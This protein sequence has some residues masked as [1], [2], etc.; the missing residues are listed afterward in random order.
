MQR[1]IAIIVIAVWL[2]LPL[3]VRADS[4]VSLMVF[5]SITL[6]QAVGLS[7]LFGFTGQISLGQA[8]F[9]GIGAYVS[10]IAAIRF[11]VP[12]LLGLVLAAIAP[13]ILAYVIGRPILRLKGY[14][15]A[16]VTAGLGLILHTVFVEWES[17]TGGY[18][19]VAGIPPL[20]IGT[21]A[22]DTPRTMF[23]FAAFCALLILIFAHRMVG[24][25]YGRAM[26]TTRE[27]EAA[28][29]SVGID[30]PRLKTEV[31][32]LS[33]G[34]SGFAGGLY[35][36]YVG[37]ISPETFTMDT[38]INLLLALVVGG[39]GSLWGGAVGAILLTFLPEWLHQLQNAYGIVFGAVVV[40][41]LTVEPD[42]LVGIV[43]RITSRWRGG[44]RPAPAGSA[45]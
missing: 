2:V 39:V 5:A 11:G 14:Y 35:A 26:R 4:T 7:L 3:V 23:Y 44:S 10:S 38:S 33:A 16:M 20:A 34:M 28:A 18:S 40:V 13:S 43:R 29:R 31:F 1:W 42:G 27:S 41:L 32:A 30:V 22:F 37:Y 8:G 25:S 12:P 36:H 24:T 17:I 19:G 9:Y 21:F 6:I 15:L 45:A